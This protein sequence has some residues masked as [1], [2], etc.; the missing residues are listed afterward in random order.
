MQKAVKILSFLF[1]LVS[2]LVLLKVLLLNFYPDFSQY[3]WGLKT[4]THGLNPYVVDKNSLTPTVYPPFVLFLL[5]FLGLLS[6]FWAE[7]IWTLISL[8]SLFASVYLIF[9][10]YRQKIFSSLGFI[11]LGL[12]SLSFPVKFTLGMG[13]INN[14][15]LFLFV[16][17]IYCLEKKKNY[18]SS[19][20]I[21]LS[22]AIKFFPIFF[23]L[24]FLVRKEWKMLLY[25]LITIFSFYFAAFLLDPKINVFFYRNVLPTFFGSWKMDY[26]NQSLSGF[27]GRSIADENIRN[28]LR[29]TLSIIFIALSFFAIFKTLRN[30]KLQNM[31]L[32]LLVSLNLIVNNFSWQHHFVFMIFPFLVT[33]FYVQKIKINLKLLFVLSVSY[34]L[35]SF[36][37]K[38]PNVV[39]VLLQSHVFYGAILLWILQVYLILKIPVKILVINTVDRHNKK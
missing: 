32:G 28:V 2:F 21:S 35:I 5:S 13:Q 4:I 36:N 18:F 6:F 14:L 30:N 17:S 33:L 10:I 39:P 31:H 37:L 8:V 19:F 12:V 9:K 38:N 26:Y 23:P 11:V 24:Y 29:Y 20:F 16:F 1:F 22:L 7:K 15:I 25:I 3:F 34:L 27:V